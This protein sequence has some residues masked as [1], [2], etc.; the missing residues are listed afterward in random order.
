MKRLLRRWYNISLSKD[1]VFV[2]SIRHLLGFIP[3]NVILFK[4]AFRHISKSQKA[5]DNNERLELLGDAILSAVTMHT[6]YLKFPY[7]EEGFLSEMRS[8]FVSRESLNSIGEKMN[9]QSM[10]ETNQK[11]I[12]KQSR[13]I[14]GNTLEA[15]IGAIYIDRGYSFAY[16][17]IQN[18][19]F[20][21]YIDWDNMD[22]SFQN[23]KSKV[24]EF[25][26]KEGNEVNFKVI[27]ETTRSKRKFFT[28]GIFINDKL[29]EKGEGF[30]KKQAE[31]QAARKI[32]D[33]FSI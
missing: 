14:L 3:V 25:G 2:S 24:L 23:Y 18:Q 30:S 28:V 1:K 26:Q 5:E 10:I 20:Q 31:Q 17:F 16:S 33:K 12:L 4:K 7:K 27:S 19:I 13:N 29:E 6:L 22:E 21:P 32:A 8:K 15:V 11:S 9:L